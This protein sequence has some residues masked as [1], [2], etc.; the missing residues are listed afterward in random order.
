MQELIGAL[1][2]FHRA[3]VA[4]AQRDYERAL[5]QGSGYKSPS[6]SRSVLSVRREPLDQEVMW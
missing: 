6:L 3:L 5:S 2:E 1:R 4:L